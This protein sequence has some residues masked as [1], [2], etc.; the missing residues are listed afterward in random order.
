MA[1]KK[2]AQVAVANDDELVTIV[3]QR[4]YDGDKRRFVSVNGKQCSILT[5]VPVK[6]PRW[7][8]RAV[9]QSEEQRESY[10]KLTE[11]LASGAAVPKN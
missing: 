1:E 8:A 5:G 10:R 11:K 9:R 7:A 3:V 4:R 2:Q 6:V